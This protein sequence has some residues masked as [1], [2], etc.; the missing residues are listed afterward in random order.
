METDAAAVHGTGDSPAAPA[1]WAPAHHGELLQSDPQRYAQMVK[2]ITG[3]G[4]YLID[5]EGRIASWNQGAA[6]ITGYTE[7]EVVGQPYGKLFSKSVDGEGLPQRTLNHAREN[8]HCRDEHRRQRHSG[9][10]FYAQCAVD[11]LRNPDGEVSGYVEVFHDITE[12]KHREDVLLQ[13]A[14]RDALTGVAN[15]GY[16]NEVASSEIARARR[17]AEPLSVIMLDIDHFKKI[18]D[19]Y[20]HDTGDRVITALA[21]TCTETMRKIDVV[22]RL[23]GEEFAVLLPRANKE[24]AL[25]IAQRLRRTVAELRVADSEGRQISFT[26]SGGVA[27]LR[28]LTRDLHELLRNADSA[29]YQAKREGRNQIRAWFD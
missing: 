11:V 15:R 23:G 25:E 5:R 19:T 8:R 1:D 14:T 21:R 2:N 24:P 4:V 18:N 12:Q 26:V 17:F 3:F 9:E 10:A 29:L 6:K 13:R 28:P 20:G 16:F 7:N 27:A 22:G